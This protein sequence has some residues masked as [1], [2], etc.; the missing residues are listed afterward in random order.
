MKFYII[1]GVCCVCT[2][3]VV[4]C[5]KAENMSPAT[6]IIAPKKKITLKIIEPVSRILV[7]KSMQVRLKSDIPLDNNLKVSYMIKST[8]AVG[9]G[10]ATVNADGILNAV[11]EGVITLI[12]TVAESDNYISTVANKTIQIISKH[13]TAAGNAST[14]DDPNGGNGELPEADELAQPDDDD[15]DSPSTTTGSP[16]A[17]QAIGQFIFQGQFISGKFGGHYG[18]GGAPKINL[19]SAPTQETKYVSVVYQRTKLLAVYKGESKVKNV[20]LNKNQPLIYMNAC[21]ST[22][23]EKPSVGQFHI[24]VFTLA[25]NSNRQD[26]INLLKKG[27]K[28]DLPTIL[29]YANKMII[30]PAIAH[31]EV[32]DYTQQ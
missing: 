30:S 12:V 6:Q 26:V 4:S 24:A 20:K 7:G 15:I 1:M 13:A 14:V 25:K 2:L 27:G 29:K 17:V 22:E 32:I 18:I 9:A 21:S 31:A 19:K 28:F 10:A 3:A 16:V 23:H 5:K 8:D 11:K